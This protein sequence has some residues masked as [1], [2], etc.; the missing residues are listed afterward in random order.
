MP[1]FVSVFVLLALLLGVPLNVGVAQSPSPAQLQPTQKTPQ[2]L[3]EARQSALEWIIEA[4]QHAP[5][6]EIW[7]GATVGEYTQFVDL[8]KQPVSIVFSVV[9]GQEEVGYVTVDVQSGYYV[10]LEAGL[11]PSLARNVV[12]AREIA[13][14]KLKASPSNMEVTLLHLG[15]MAYLAQ[16]TVRTKEGLENMIIHLGSLEEM[17]PSALKQIPPE[18]WKDRL[19]RRKAV[20][21]PSYG[22]HTISGVP[23]Y[24]MDDAPW[25]T[26]HCG[27]TSGAN[28]YGYWKDHGFPDLWPGSVSALIGA[29][30]QYMGTNSGHPGT[31]PFEYADGM[32]SYADVHGYPGTST[33]TSDSRMIGPR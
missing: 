14:Q 28:V 15:P 11:S 33:Y 17:P 10:V 25:L 31:Y 26:N 21:T 6:M 29:L 16:F 2:G 3:D 27:P 24:I 22:G 30:Y 19:R 1:K 4:S 9:K 13:S 20:A 32:E 12:Q 5:G 18:I 8:E 23:Y 7:N